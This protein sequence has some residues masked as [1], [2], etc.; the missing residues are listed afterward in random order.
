MTGGAR[1]DAGFWRGRDVFVTGHTGF[2]GSWLSLWLASLGARVHGYSLPPEAGG[3]GETPLFL[4][5]GVREVLASHV[6]AD[7]RDRALLLEKWRASDAGVL[8]H[9]AAQPLVRE[10]YRS[11][12]ETFEVNVQGTAS[13]LEALRLVGRPAAAVMVTTDKVY[14]N[15]EEIWGRRETDPLG[16]HDPYSASK[17]AAELVTVAYRSS[18]FQPASGRPAVRVAT[19]RA[20]NVIGGGDWA[21][22]RLVPDMSRALL[23]GREAEIRNPKSVRPWQHVLEPLAGYMMLAEFLRGDADNPL[24]RSAW[25]F[26]P[27]PLDL[28]PV[29]RVADVFCRGWGEGAGWRNLAEPDAPFETSFLHL[30]TD[31]TSL[32]MGWRPRWTTGEAVEKSALWYRRSVEPGFEARS[33]CLG[34]VA[35]YMAAQK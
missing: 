14:E 5:A 30:N 4:S 15:F 20:G 10:S 16:G 34:D 7:I 1:P 29:E 21:R 17:A 24:W 2:K 32:R 22:D 8:F 3:G 11:P 27:D 33:A 19:A 9:L 12:Y 6:E 18:F 13:V 28:W 25:N 23:S 35:D 26:G 31:K